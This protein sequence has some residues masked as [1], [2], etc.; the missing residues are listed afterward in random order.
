MYQIVGNKVTKSFATQKKLFKDAAFLIPQ[1]QL[2]K[3]VTL[4]RGAGGQ[5]GVRQQL[6]GLQGAAWHDGGPGRQGGSQPSHCQGAGRIRNRI[7]F[8]RYLV[9]SL[10]WQIIQNGIVL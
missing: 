7:M 9:D 1:D 2:G 3:C 5:P 10:S 8:S 6:A 4:L